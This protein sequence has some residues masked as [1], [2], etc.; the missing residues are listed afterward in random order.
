M[1]NDDEDNEIMDNIDIGDMQEA[2]SEANGTVIKAN[3]ITNQTEETKSVQEGKP[4]VKAGK[5]MI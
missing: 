5:Y 2:L 3:T 4:A 1:L